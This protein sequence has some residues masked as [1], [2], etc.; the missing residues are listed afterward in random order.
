M[1]K[2]IMNIEK[3]NTQGEELKKIA[4]DYNKIIDD[5][6][7]KLADINNDGVFLSDSSTGAASKLIKSSEIDKKNLETIGNNMYVLGD[8]IVNYSKSIKKTSD[9]SIGG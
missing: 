2:L 3:I 9:D 7:K 1:A 5:T 6:Y 8:K 4:K